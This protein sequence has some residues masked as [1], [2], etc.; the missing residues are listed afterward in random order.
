LLGRV[1]RRLPHPATYAAIDELIQLRQIDGLVAIG[2][3]PALQ[4]FGNEIAKH[5]PLERRGQVRSLS[6]GMRAKHPQR[7]IAALRD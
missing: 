2:I 6:G 1:T 4:P 5:R 7:F 3:G